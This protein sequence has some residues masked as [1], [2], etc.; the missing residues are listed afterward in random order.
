M[1][2][3]DVTSPETGASLIQGSEALA[4]RAGFARRAMETT[5]S[6]FSRRLAG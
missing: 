1:M 3:A 2:S 6:R 4:S 5:M